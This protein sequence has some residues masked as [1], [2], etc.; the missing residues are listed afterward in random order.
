MTKKSYKIALMGAGRM[1]NKRAKALEAHPSC[2][3]QVVVDVDERRAKDLAQRYQCEWE[4]DWSN[5]VGNK[6]IDIVIVATI[7]KFLK[8]ISLAALNN[9]KHVLCE[10]PLGCNAKESQVLV[11]AA[12]ENNRILKTGLNH[13]HHPAIKMAKSLFDEGSIGPLCF[14]RA[15]YGHGGREGYDKE[16]RCQKTLAGGGQL[17]DQGVHIIDLFRWFAGDFFEVFAKTTTN[18]WDIQVEDNAFAVL[19]NR[20]N[21]VAS[22][23]TSWTQWRNLFCLEIFGSQG[24]LLVEGLGGH[25]GLETLKVGSRQEDSPVPKEVT[26]EFPQDDVSWIE[27]WREFLSAIENG[28]QPLGSGADGYEA[29]R[30]V[31]ALYTSAQEGKVVAL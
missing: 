2:S 23:H 24:Y 10:K 7:N 6:E 9:K 22:M 28:T 18:H 4:T 17:L 14:I 20:Q 1:G 25:Y 15:R 8:P 11:D 16:W 19:K 29:N 30:I 3:L 5:V 13:R 27:E 26:Y 31:D 12:Q 21:V